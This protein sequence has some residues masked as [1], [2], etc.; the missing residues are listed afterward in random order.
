MVEG[1]AKHVAGLL[2]SPQM[3]QCIDQP[4][5]ADKESRLRNTEV[6]LS[7]V[8]HNV[9]STHEF[10]KNCVHR[11]NKA[12]VLGVDQAKFR[13]KQH[14]RIHIVAANSRPEHAPRLVPSS[15]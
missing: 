4:E 8:S 13:Q 10:P 12:W 14:A 6:I 2:R 1:I 3:P 15:L 5:S 7:R 9:L 11:G